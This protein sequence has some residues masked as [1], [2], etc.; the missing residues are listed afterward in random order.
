MP[1]TPSAWTRSGSRVV[2]HWTWKPGSISARCLQAASLKEMN[3]IRSGES[4][5]WR[6]TASTARSARRQA[7][8]SPPSFLTSR[9]SIVDFERDPCER[10]SLSVG[11]R[12]PFD[13]VKSAMAA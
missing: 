9:T 4:R 3:M 12:S 8:A 7:A 5:P 2:T 6:R 13:S 1:G 11:R 10:Y